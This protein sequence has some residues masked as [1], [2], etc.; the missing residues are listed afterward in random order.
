MHYLT[1]LFRVD[2]LTNGGMA[3]KKK[4]ILVLL[5][6]PLSLGIATLISAPTYAVMPCKK[7]LTLPCWYSGLDEEDGS[8]VIKKPQDIW[9][10]VLNFIDMAIQA[11]GYLAAAFIIWGGFKFLISEGNSDKAAAAR[12]TIINASAG[13]LLALASVAIIKFVSTLL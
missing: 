3:M 8:P 9:I 2:Y 5:S 4:I 13:L 12:K 10:I 7:I 6:L 1:F 11:V